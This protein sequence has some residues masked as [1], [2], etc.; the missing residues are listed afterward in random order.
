MS[1]TDIEKIDLISTDPKG[2]IRLTI[3]DHL[4][5]EEEESHLRTLQ[6]KINK[7]LEFIESGQIYDDY[8]EAKGKELRIDVVSK[9]DLT[10]LGNDF[11]RIVDDK[12]I[13]SGLCRIN[14]YKL[15]DA[16]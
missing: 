14:Q 4:D 11:I 10:E 3:S 12:L 1:V 6:D 5:W 8:P 16:K 2:V 9:Y 13:E 7:Y 15:E